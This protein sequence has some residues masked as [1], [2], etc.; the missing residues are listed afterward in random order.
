M[1]RRN[2]AARITRLVE[3]LLRVPPA[4]YADD[5]NTASMPLGEKERWGPGQIRQP[6]TDF[7]VL[8]QGS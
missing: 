8:S 6:W 5:H 2:S 7:D 4:R 1:A 3:F